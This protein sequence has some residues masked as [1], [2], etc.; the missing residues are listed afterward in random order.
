[1]GTLG[2]RDDWR[3]LRHFRIL[4]PCQVIPGWISSESRVSWKAL[5]FLSPPV[6][7]HTE[8]QRTQPHQTPGC[9]VLSKWSTSKPSICWETSSAVRPRQTSV[10][11]AM[12]VRWGELL[13]WGTQDSQM[14]LVELREPR[15]L[16]AVPTSNA[17]DKVPAPLE[18]P[19][20][21]TLSDT[22]GNIPH[23]SPGSCCCPSRVLLSFRGSGARIFGLD[24][25]QDPS[26]W[27]Y[28]D[29]RNIPGV[30]LCLG[31]VEHMT[32]RESIW[33]NGE[34]GARQGMELTLLCLPCEQQDPDSRL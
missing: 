29:S 10:F 11:R 32:L 1:M 15:E 14:Q 30:G 33:C 22:A 17:P 31:A 20:H 7:I 19:G 9:R 23:T 6:P 8:M 2:C 27:L 16:L 3:P 18:P 24:S 25:R 4:L 34:R 21:R 13:C 28:L 5:C 26:S 12:R